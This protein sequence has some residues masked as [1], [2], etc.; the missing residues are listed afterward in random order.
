MLVDVTATA[1]EAGIRYPVAVTRALWDRH[2][3]VPRR[4][5]G[6]QDEAGRLWDALWMFRQAAR[7][8]GS[9]V[10]FTV[11][12]LERPGRRPVPR[13]VR[14][15]CG[16]GDHGEPVLTLLPTRTDPPAIP[17]GIFPTVGPPSRS[18]PETAGGGIAMPG[19]RRIPLA[20]VRVRCPDFWGETYCWRHARRYRALC[21]RDP[22]TCPWEVLYGRGPCRIAH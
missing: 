16:P 6:L 21:R 11:L 5:E 2:I 22:D 3:A 9:T 18:R 10:T 7:R 17:T 20:I 1:R 19:L 12:F 15:V 14:A 4:L 13:Q 8:G